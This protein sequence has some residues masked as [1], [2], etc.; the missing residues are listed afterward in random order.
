MFN[1]NNLPTEEHAMDTFIMFAKAYNV[2]Y[3]ANR[4]DLLEAIDLEIGDI[5]IHLQDIGVEAMVQYEVKPSG[6]AH[7]LEITFLNE[8]GSHWSKRVQR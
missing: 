3:D 5:A 7:I 8:N 6:R 4:K 1:T 2:A